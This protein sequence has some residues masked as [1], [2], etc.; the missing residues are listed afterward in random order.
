VRTCSDKL[1]LDGEFLRIASRGLRD[2]Q[3]II[4]ALGDVLG[5]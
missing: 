2:N 1:G 4:D 3:R 5:E